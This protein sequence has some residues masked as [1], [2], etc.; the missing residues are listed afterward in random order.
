[1]ME[2]YFNYPSSQSY[3]TWEKDDGDFEGDIKKERPPPK[4][5]DSHE[6]ENDDS[7]DHGAEEEH[8]GPSICFNSIFT[9]R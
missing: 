6:E 2:K 3:M 9:A 4:T 8:P 1:M 5:N 7:I